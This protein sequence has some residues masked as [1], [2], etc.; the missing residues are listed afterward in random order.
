[1]NEFMDLR[2]RAKKNIQ[3]ADHMITMS[4]PLFKDPKILVSA[5]NSLLKAMENAISSV[6]EYEKLFKRIPIYHDSLDVK[7]NLFK[8]K[9]V[10]RYKLN[11]KHIKLVKTLMDLSKAHKESSIEFPRKDKF[12]ICSDTYELRTITENDLKNLI[13]ETKSL[14][15]DIYQVTRKNDRIFK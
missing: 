1:M 15:E 7:A 6:L 8:E 10:P 13:K 12:V 11:E 5:V 9:I 14:V 2:E 3:I 4:Y